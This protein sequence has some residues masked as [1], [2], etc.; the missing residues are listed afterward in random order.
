MGAQVY[1]AEPFGPVEVPD[2]MVPFVERRGLPLQVAPL[3]ADEKTA[4]KAALEKNKARGADTARLER[5]LRSTRSDLA[6]ANE[7]LAAEKNAATKLEKKAANLASK[8]AE[9]NE[10]LATCRADLKALEAKLAE[11]STVIV[12]LEQKTKPR[13]RSRKKSD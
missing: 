9:S 7:E 1:E 3:G 10:Q 8:L 12:E 4:R 5:E 13:T 2:E 11:Q 6:A